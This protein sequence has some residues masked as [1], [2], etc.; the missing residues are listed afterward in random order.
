M[1]LLRNVCSIANC[2][3][4]VQMRHFIVE[5]TNA[6]GFLQLICLIPPRFQPLI[7]LQYEVGWIKEF[8][9]QLP[10]LWGRQI[11]YRPVLTRP[12]SR[13]RFLPSAADSVLSCRQPTCWLSRR[14]ICKPSPAERY[15]SRSSMLSI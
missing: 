6:H 15:P 12:V 13:C 14:K 4:T 1:C 5:L 8:I 10:F 7:W 9:Y 3:Q 11:E 2:I